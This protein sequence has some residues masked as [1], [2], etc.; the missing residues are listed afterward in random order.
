MRPFFKDSLI[1]I[2]YFV[3]IGVVVVICNLKMSTP[4]TDAVAR[5]LRKHEFL[6]LA[7]VWLVGFMFC[8]RFIDKQEGQEYWKKLKELLLPTL[9]MLGF[10]VLILGGLLALAEL[11][12]WLITSVL[13]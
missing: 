5:F 7:L 3:G 12:E 2:L 10:G 11:A 9:A 4:S 8:A 1:T 13:L 6:S